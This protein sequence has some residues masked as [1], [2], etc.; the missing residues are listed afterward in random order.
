MALLLSACSATV[1]EPP[2]KVRERDPEGVL[3]H[4][5]Q[6]PWADVARECTEVLGPA[7]VAGVQ[8]SPPQEHI[9]APG[10]PWWQD[11]QP[12]GYR[13]QSRRGDRQAFAA[14]VTQC[15]TAGVK[16]Y[17]D[18]VLN[19]RRGALPEE[20]HHCGRS[21]SNYQDRFEVQHCDLLGLPDLA[22]ESPAVQAQLTAYLNDLISL[23]VDGFRIDAAKHIPALD[24]RKII[25]AGPKIYSEVLYSPTEPI[26]P[27]EYL[28]FGATLEPRYA[29][30]ISRTF[31][32][33]SFTLLPDRLAD[34]LPAGVIYVDS[35]DTQRGTSTMS[36]K[37]DPK[38]TLAVL[39]MLAGAYGT[40]LLMSSYAF[41]SF[42]EGPPSFPVVC[43]TQWLCEHRKALKM[44][45]W[46]K[47]MADAPQQNWWATDDQLGFTRAGKGY[48]ALNR[49]NTAVTKTVETGLTPGSYRDVLSGGSI[50]VDAAGKAVLTIPATGAIALAKE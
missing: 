36:Y 38:H 40:P 14:M 9:S 11:Y 32:G 27:T 10:S 15:H 1:P 24:L 45:A 48:F 39:F 29:E 18:A 25:P 44:V 23:G 35:H 21:I 5:F 34:L 4:L 8:I 41:E 42:D 31:R 12:T 7:G 33:D 22:T 30:K 16:I 50:Q 17:A 6:W 26:Q 3:V 13:I 47:S 49:A 43:G 37:E 46:R 2:E 19:H 28:D 20:L